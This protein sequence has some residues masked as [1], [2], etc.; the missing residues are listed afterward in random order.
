MAVYPANNE[1]EFMQW[2]VKYDLTFC[3]I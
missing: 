3:R 1:A 2:H